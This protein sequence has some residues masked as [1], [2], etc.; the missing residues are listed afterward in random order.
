MM[1]TGRTSG[2]TVAMAMTVS[3]VV[4]SEDRGDRRVADCSPGTRSAGSRS[5]TRAI[6]WS[7]SSA[8]PT[9]SGCR[10]P[11]SRGPAGTA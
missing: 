11:R 7:A 10:A 5:S 9:S 6:T 1:A 8:R 4:V 2:P 3:P